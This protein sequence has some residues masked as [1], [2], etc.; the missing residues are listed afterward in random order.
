MDGDK[1]QHDKKL[2]IGQLMKDNVV[3]MVDRN[4][5]NREALQLN[6]L[7]SDAGGQGDVYHV[8]FKS[9]D[10]ALKWYCKQPDD[11]IGGMQHKTISRIC[12][13]EKR[14]N[15][16]FIWPL[17]MVSEQ[18]SCEGRRFGYLM[19]LLPEGYH[20]MSCFLKNSEDPRAITFESYNAM[21][22]A[23]M[24][25]ASAMQ[26]LH[27]KGWSY[28]DLNPKNFTIN[29]KNGDVLVV[30]NDN[31][32]VDGDLCSV[33]GMKG[34]MAPE[35]PRSDYKQNPNRETDYYSLAVVL[36]HLFFIDNPMD[37]KI[38][39][40][41]PIITDKVEDDI[42]AI[43]PIFHFDPND[44]SNRPTDVYAPNALSRWRIFNSALKKL[45]TRSF[46]VGIDDPNKRPPENEWILTLSKVRD[47][48]IRLNPQREQFV[49][50]DD[51]RS[52]P[53]RCLGMKIGNH[54]IAIYPNKVL[55]E[56]SINGDHQKYNV[57]VGKIVYDRESDQFKIVNLSPV[58][59]RCYSPVTGQ[60]SEV[61][62][63]ASHPLFDGVMIE[64][65]RE[66]PKIVGE[67]FDPF[68]TVQ[69]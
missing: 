37:G 43:K 55:Y 65:Q 35:I 12:G 68:K 54:R 48:L 7:I 16:K 20:E 30:D 9:K 13:E 38:L 11:V 23:G 51:I 4:D 44:D 47:T 6:H 36:Y 2:K 14:P 5:E 25:I 39:E 45:F 64:F 17:M 59:W 34:Y 61:G 31:V 27:Y 42:Y 1:N 63:E 8:S 57:K 18:N 50:F 33:R 41:Y 22:T 32:S 66:N 58:V 53:P 10:Y 49:N 19:E 46:T 40:N 52:V 60:V 28:K 29:P 15:D 67:I 26:T 24:N 3:I 21:I 62:K 69:R 56:I